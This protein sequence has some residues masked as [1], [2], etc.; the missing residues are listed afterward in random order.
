MVKSPL[1]WFGGKAML[2]EKI[3]ELMPSHS[4]Y[5]EPFGGAAHV[6]AVK[7]PSKVD[8]YNDIN[9]DVVNFLMV[10]RKDPDRL[11]DAC[12]SLP[13][14]RFLFE[15]WQ[16]ELFENRRSEGTMNDFERA[17]KFFYVNRCGINGGGLNHKS[18]WKHSVHHNTPAV[19][20]SICK[21]MKDF[22]E[23]MRSVF[24]ECR[25]FRYI[26]K[27]YDGP[28]TLFYIDPPYVGCESRY[29]GKFSEK[30]HRELAELL[31]NIKGKAI[32]SYYAD[33]L[34]NQLYYGWNRLELPAKK[35]TV[36]SGEGYTRPDATELLLTNFENK[37]MSIFEFA[38]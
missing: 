9:G 28:E 22:G 26:I 23:R 3:I 10:L 5:V 32:V 37:Q 4:C 27:T 13:Y 18:G 11:E 25:D 35:N 12:S 20:Q 31:C 33:D 15:T 36:V 2:A 8:V 29:T 21:R 19:Y 17:V 14:S 1:I 34:V 24:I 16:N 7:T 6:M 30:D 38:Q